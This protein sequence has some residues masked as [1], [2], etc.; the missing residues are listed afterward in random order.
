MIWALQTKWKLKI[1]EYLLL[2]GE[3]TWEEVRPSDTEGDNS[4][5]N[6]TIQ[7]VFQYQIF[8]LVQ[9]GIVAVK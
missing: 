7:V 9:T 2:I 1:K 8:F 5:I 4:E 3:S 6:W